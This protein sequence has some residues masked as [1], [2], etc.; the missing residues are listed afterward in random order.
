MEV[1]AS[2]RS[3]RLSIHE[4]ADIAAAHVYWAEVVRVPTE[5]FQ[6]PT[7]KRHNPKTVRRN[8]GQDYRGCL[9]IT[10]SQSRVLYQQIDGLFHGLVASVSPSTPASSDTE[11]TV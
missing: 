9:I 3:Y 11:P 4:T 10:V 7:L 2:R 8:T 1:T 5:L 6:R